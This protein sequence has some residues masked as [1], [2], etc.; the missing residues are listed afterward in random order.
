MMRVLRNGDFGCH[1]RRE[2]HCLPG[3]KQV[4]SNAAGRRNHRIPYGLLAKTVVCGVARLANILDIRFAARRASVPFW[5]Q[6]T[7]G[8]LR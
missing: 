6:R 4:T 3:G 8:S 5:P 2:E 1:A 7:R